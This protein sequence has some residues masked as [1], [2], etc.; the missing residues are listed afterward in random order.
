NKLNKRKI[1]ENIKF[2]LNLQPEWKG[3]V[4]IIKQT[5]DLH[6]T[7]YNKI[8]HILKQNQDEA[9]EVR[10]ERMVTTIN[11]LAIV[12]TTMTQ[13]PIPS[14]ESQSSSR[15]KTKARD[16]GHY[17]KDCKATTRAMYFNYFKRRMLLENKEESEILLNE[18]EYDFLAETDGGEVDQKINVNCIFIAKIQ[19]IHE[20][21]SDIKVDNGPSYD[22]N[23]LTKVKFIEN[24]DYNM[25]AH[26]R[27]H[28]EQ[29]ESIHDTYVMEH[30]DS[31]DL[32][33]SRDMDQSR[34]EDKYDD[35]CHEHGLSSNADI[36]DSFPSV[37]HVT[38]T[39]Q[40]ELFVAMGSD[41]Q[42]D[43]AKAIMLRPTRPNG[44]VSS[45]V[46][47]SQPDVT[48]HAQVLFASLVGCKNSKCLVAFLAVENY[49][50]NA[51]KKF[52]PIILKEPT[53]DACLLKENLCSALV[54]VKLHDIPIFAFTEDGSSAMTGQI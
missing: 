29:L 52:V 16:T 19:D 26:E 6:V 35:V 18:K 34:G 53:P 40:Y 25:F 28:P 11:L 33:A 4:T 24:V 45:K 23:G 1:N 30:D 46:C 13:S 36:Q 9:N 49:V 42:Q 12:A 31:D 44:V 47:V 37:E 10:A 20:A 50:K 39:D 3:Y 5:K 14:N 27:R 2:L 8:F 38:N 51:W 43:E 15:S 7:D 17:A 41:L 21:L 54:R 22:T 48:Q 32:S